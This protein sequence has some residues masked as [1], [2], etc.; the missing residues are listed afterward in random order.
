MWQRGSVLR[1]SYVWQINRLPSFTTR[2]RT[3]EQQGTASVLLPLAVVTAADW[4][5]HLPVETIN[6]SAEMIHV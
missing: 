6:V 1:L 3:A 5:D 4:I 2:S